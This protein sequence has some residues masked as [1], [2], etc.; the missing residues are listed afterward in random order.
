MGALCIVAQ[1]LQKC[2]APLMN[3]NGD[4]IVE[5]SLLELIGNELRTSPTLE[6]DAA[7]LGEELKPPEVPEAAGSLH[8]CPETS[9]P[10]GIHCTD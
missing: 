9:E 3:L 7:L 8:K 5:A 10:E 6:E 4:D 2:M 1:E